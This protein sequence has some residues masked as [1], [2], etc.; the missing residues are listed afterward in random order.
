[1]AE[2]KK[3][4]ARSYYDSLRAS[5]FESLLD[6]ANREESRRNKATKDFKQQKAGLTSSL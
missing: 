6:A 1:M 4:R 5:Q 3:E 2:S